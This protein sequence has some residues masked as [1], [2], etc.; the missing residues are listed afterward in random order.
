MGNRGRSR[1]A[2]P[3]AVRR[4]AMRQGALALPRPVLVAE[5]LLLFVG[6]PLLYVWRR[7]PMHILTVLWLVTAGCLV[8]LL[9]DPTFDRGRLWRW[10]GQGAE[11]RRVGTRFV[12]VAVTA[13]AAHAAFGPGVFLA[14]PRQ[15]AGTW[16]L[17]IALYPFVS[18]LPQAVVYR[19]FFFHRYRSLFG[20]GWVMVGASAAVFCLGHV[21]FRNEVAIALT[22]AGGLLFAHTYRR[23]GSLLV[24][25][26]E[27][28]L[29]GIL[30]FTLGFGRFLGVG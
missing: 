26:L 2:W 5:L 1:S 13:V 22:A 23:C 27:H 14:F 19:A 15:H 28:A 3:E 4:L 25:S 18:V 7:P 6:L 17:L 21:V 16:G 11:L 12:V 29:Y 20:T 8:S 24:S 30:I 10:R 9:L